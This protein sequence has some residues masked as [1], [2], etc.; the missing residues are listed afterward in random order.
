MNGINLL[1]IG[2]VVM[3]TSQ[4]VIKCKFK[5]LTNRKMSVFQVHAP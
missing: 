3:C 2:L 5:N 1:F 4:S